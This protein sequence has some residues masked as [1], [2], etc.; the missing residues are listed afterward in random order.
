MVAVWTAYEIG[1]DSKVIR[2]IVLAGCYPTLVEPLMNS[3]D[4]DSDDEA[5]ADPVELEMA[6]EPRAY[7]TSRARGGEAQGVRARGT[8]E[9]PLTPDP[10]EPEELVEEDLVEQL[11]EED[12][13]EEDLVEEIIDELPQARPRRTREIECPRDPVEVLRMWPHSSSVHDHCPAQPPAAPA[14][15][16]GKHRADDKIALAHLALD[17][18]REIEGLPS[19]T[20]ACNNQGCEARIQALRGALIE[21]CLLVQR[22]VMMTTSGK[23]EIEVRVRE[24]LEL[25]EP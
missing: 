10:Q 13:V 9:R 12:L 7:R 11:V 17:L 3:S 25:V 1:V 4:G 24:L 16:A 19:A 22:A 14:R 2:A 6:G 18:Y 15:P 20:A 5:M 23:A 21:A 8:R